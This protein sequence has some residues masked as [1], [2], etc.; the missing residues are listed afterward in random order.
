M[1]TPTTSRTTFQ[2]SELSRSSAEVF[3]AAS[4]HP[5]RVTRRDGE[6]LVLM[7]ESA[8]LARASLLELAAQLVAVS[9]S[10][11]GTLASKMSDRFPWMLALSPAD[12]EACASQILAAARASFATNQPHLAISE[13]TSWR[14]SATAIAAGLGKEPVEWLDAVENVERP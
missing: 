14:E 9:T 13:L 8:D 12:Q 2:S 4:D 6:A 1:S 3:A 11:D 5:V 7:S 10:T